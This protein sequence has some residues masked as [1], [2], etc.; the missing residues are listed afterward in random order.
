M[1]AETMHCI[2]RYQANSLHFIAGFIWNWT[3]VN[4]Q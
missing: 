1:T 4:R 3:S 2:I